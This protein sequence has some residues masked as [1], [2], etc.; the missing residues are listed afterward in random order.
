MRGVR[1]CAHCGTLNGNRA[2]NR[3]GNTSCPQHKNVLD[4]VQ[5]VC[6]RPGITLYS[7]RT[8]EKD[9]QPRNFVVIEDITLS[10]HLNAAVVS[11]KAECH[12]ENCKQSAVPPIRDCIHVK[13]CR[14][15]GTEIPKAQVFKVTREVLWNL[16]IREEQKQQ[17][18]QLYKQAEEQE[19]IPAVQRLNATTFA[20]KCERSESF[21]AAR[22]HVTAMSSG[23]GCYACACKKLKIIVEPDNSLVMQDEICDHLLLVLAGILSS[24]QGKRIYGNFTNGLQSFWMP[25][26]LET[27]LEEGV[28]EDLRLSLVDDFDPQVDILVF[29]D[30]LDLSMPDLSEGVFNLDNMQAATSSQSTSTATNALVH[31]ANDS[32]VLANCD[33][34]A[35][36][37][38]LTD[39]NIELMDQFQPTDQIDLTSEE[40]QLPLIS[41]PYNILAAPSVFAESSPAVVSDQLPIELAT[42]AVVKKTPVKASEIVNEVKSRKQ[43]PLPAKRDLI[44][45]NCNT[46]AKCRP[47]METICLDPSVQPSLSY[48]AWLEHVIELLNESLEPSEMPPAGVSKRVVE[49]KFH[50]HREIFSHF[51]KSFSA[52]IKRRPL[53]KILVIESGKYKGLTKYV[54]HFTT[55][56]NVKRIFNTSN[57]SIQMD[58]AFERDKE[59]NFVPYVRPA[60]DYILPGASRKRPM[61]KRLKLYM[62]RIIF[63]DAPKEQ[64]GNGLLVTWTPDVLPHSQFGLMHLEFV[65][66]TKSPS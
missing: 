65:V 42:I 57:I 37:I 51:C 33:V 18:W 22:L 61:Y 63:E 4:A 49:H 1:K 15:L 66:E 58:R 6:L 43:P 55:S 62:P 38:A 14:E 30:H 56:H 27:P 59:G 17:L 32:Q 28:P 53:D 8:K 39:C 13:S 3:C 20:V 34:Y 21:P 26:Q 19:R 2:G 48:S 25:M 40:I 24:P 31:Y 60:S 35:E 9:H 45:N 64:K 46:A 7:L 11:S 36:P 47:I 5:L 41:E 29:G 44:V 12:A 52:G 23:K 54:W 10:L 16:N 50:V